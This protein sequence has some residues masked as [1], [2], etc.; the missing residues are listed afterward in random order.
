MQK[1]HVLSL[2][3]LYKPVF[4]YIEEDSHVPVSLFS[5]ITKLYLRFSLWLSHFQLILVSF[6]T[7][8]FICYVAASRRLFLRNKEK[9]N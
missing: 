2:N 9:A 7:I 8:I 6:V 5:T 1:N 4:L 3:T